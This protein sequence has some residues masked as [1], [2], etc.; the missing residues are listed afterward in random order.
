M[1]DRAKLRGGQAANAGAVAASGRG[2]GKSKAADPIAAGT[3]HEQR[4]RYHHGDLPAALMAAG[5]VELEAHGIEGFSLRAVAKRAGVSHAAPAHHF[6]D[7]NGLLTALTSDAFRRFIAA[8]TERQ[9]AAAPDALSQCIAS[10]VGYVMFA[11]A[12]P[13]MFRLMFSS[14]RPQFDD[15][16]LFAASCAALDKL[17]ADVK[18]MSGTAVTE[19]ELRRDAIVVWS[20]AHGLADLIN[21]GRLPGFDEVSREALAVRVE[22]LL[23][24]GLSHLAASGADQ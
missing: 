14:G 16:D 13:A 11:A 21:G 2:R 1:A 20:L 3:D 8:Q 10:G 18:A 19:D 6:G 17:A 23:R 9:R 4:E 22:A 5:E 24:R 7:A 15:P 12:H